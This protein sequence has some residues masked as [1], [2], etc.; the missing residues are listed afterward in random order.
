MAILVVFE[1]PNISKKQY[2]DLRPVVKWET[3]HPAG[4]VCHSCAFDDKGAMHVIDVWNSEAELMNFFETRLMPGFKKLN[5][6]PPQP[7]IYPLHNLNVFAP[8]DQH[9]A[10]SR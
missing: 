3:E 10:K 7:K 5:I 8:A 2:E 4:I 1:T 6:T 9:R